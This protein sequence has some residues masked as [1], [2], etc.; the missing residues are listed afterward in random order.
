MIAGLGAVDPFIGDQDDD[1]EEEEEEERRE[2]VSVMSG[3]RSCFR[4]VISASSAACNFDGGCCLSGKSNA[5]GISKAEHAMPMMH[6]SH[7]FRLRVN[8]LTVRARKFK[9]SVSAE[10][11]YKTLLL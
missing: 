8:E 4:E 10:R 2:V 5:N 6:C 11:L 3:S 9:S 7:T 1:V